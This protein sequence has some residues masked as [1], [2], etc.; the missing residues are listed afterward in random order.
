MRATAALEQV[1]SNRYLWIL[2]KCIDGAVRQIGE[3]G[4]MEKRKLARRWAGEVS[5]PELVDRLELALTE[6]PPGASVFKALSVLSYRLGSASGPGAEQ[7]SR[8]G[9]SR[10]ARHTAVESLPLFS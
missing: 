4:L 9:V 3:M 8:P 2:N 6:M 1:R 7:K 5:L 10:R